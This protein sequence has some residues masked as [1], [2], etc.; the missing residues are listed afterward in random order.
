MHDGGIDTP[1]NQYRID[2]DTSNGLPW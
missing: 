2:E 1:E